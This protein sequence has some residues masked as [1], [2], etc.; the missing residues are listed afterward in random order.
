MLFLVICDMEGIHISL[1]WRGA[2]AQWTAKAVFWHVIVQ[3]HACSSALLCPADVVSH[4][5]L[6]WVAIAATV[7]MRSHFN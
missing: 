7:L 2:R 5:Y 1:N 4:F 6:A 3:C